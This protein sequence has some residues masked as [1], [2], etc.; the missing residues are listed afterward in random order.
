MDR[1]RK[2]IL[3]RKQVSTSSRSNVFTYHS[4]VFEIVSLIF[5]S[6]K[7]ESLHLAVIT[8]D[9]LCLTERTQHESDFFGCPQNTPSET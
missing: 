5:F 7:S 8:Q 6:F 2:G 4:L 3:Q 1:I 9:A